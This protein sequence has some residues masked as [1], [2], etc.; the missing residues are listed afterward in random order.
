MKVFHLG[1]EKPRKIALGPQIYKVFKT[2]GIIGQFL[3][4]DTNEKTVSIKKEH[5]K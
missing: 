1:D 4:E 5:Y 3:S 2:G